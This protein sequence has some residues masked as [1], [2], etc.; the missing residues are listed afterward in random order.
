MSKNFTSWLLFTI[1]SLIWGSSFIFIKF[2][3][4][5]LTAWQMAALRIASAGLV[6]LPTAT[7]SFRRMPRNKLGYIVL[8]GALG[9]FFPAFLFCLAEVGISSSLAGTI[10]AL[11][12]IFVIAI[13]FLFF[14]SRVSAHKTA[15]VLVA[16]AGC[17]LLL[18]S[19]GAG[20]NQNPFYILFVVAATI[21][22]GFNINLVGRHLGQI[23][24]LQLAA[25]A[26]VANAIP[27]LLI[28]VFTG[29]F[30]LPFGNA[31]LL[32]SLSAGAALGIIATALATVLFYRLMQV[33]GAVFSSMVTYGIPVVA[34]GWGLLYN[35]SIGWKQ[36]ICLLLILSGVFIANL[37]MLVTAAKTR[38]QGRH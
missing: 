24:S 27:A 17:I 5:A 8:S 32:K 13:G 3:L 11:T 19:K 37:E 14:G 28:L 29:F 12:P 33:A 16:F 9:S 26:L 38:M 6:L 34:I 7:R 4:E 25:V 10:N 2:G 22:Y 20:S 31:A 35:E 21:C 15:G 1:L 30:Q 18:L 36:V 23:P